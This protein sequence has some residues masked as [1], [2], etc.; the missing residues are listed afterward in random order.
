[1]E[2]YVY[3]KVFIEERGRFFLNKQSLIKGTLIL[4]IGGIIT[5]F[6]G[7]FFRLP[8]TMLIGDEGLGYYQMS[9]PLYMFYVAVATGIPVAISKMVSEKNA[10]GDTEGILQVFRKAML[11]M[12]ILG[13]GF[14]L[15]LIFGSRQ[16]IKVFRWDEKAYFSLIGISLAPLLISVM[17]V[18][19]GFF[20]GFQNMNP[21]AVSQLIE[22]AARV[23]I[24]V[25]LAYVL[26]PYG[27]EYSAG[28][29]AFGAAAGAVAGVM[30]LSGRYLLFIKKYSH[31]KKKKEEETLNKLLYIAVPI[32]MGATVGSIMSLIDS[33]LVPQKLLQAG[34]TYKECTVLFGQLTGKAFILI[35]VP[36]TISIALCAAIVPVISEAIVLNRRQEVVKRIDMALR[37]SMVIAIPSF[38]GLFFMANPILRLLLP[39]HSE[40]HL[41][42]KYLSIS[43]PFIILTQTTTAILQG[44]GYYFRPVL[45]LVIGCMI[46]VVLTYILVPLPGVNIYGSIIGTV[47]AY[48]VTS[49]ANL[50]LIH[51]KLKIRINYYE[52]L[53]KPAFAAVFMIFGVVIVYMRVYNYTKSNFYACLT[54]I[55]TGL[56]I[57][58]MLIFFFGIM[59]YSYFKKRFLK[60]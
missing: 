9:Y 35:N 44:T 11:L 54:S 1:M 22:Q 47:A 30:Y 18:F 51:S 34:L 45:N 8:L 6:L 57:Y 49:A 40:G 60:M 17:S 56:I 3:F 5:R 31:L 50:H 24:G 10:I 43:V 29:A 12:L 39:G 55:S 27:I 26:L 21:T 42:L 16:L 2:E 32:S 52:I 7:L 53:I 28:G 14:S 15:F 36:L 58:V 19:R 37:L 41:I 20:Q 48:I 23:L 46:K 4:G 13:G 59:N 38:L 25:G 33:I